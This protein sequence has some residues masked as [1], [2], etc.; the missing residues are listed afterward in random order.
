VFSGHLAPKALFRRYVWDRLSQAWQLKLVQWRRQLWT[1]VRFMF[2]W[3]GVLWLVWLIDRGLPDAISFQRLGIQPREWRGLLGI[4]LAPFIH[5]KPDPWYA[6]PWHLVLNTV[7]FFLLG[8]L[9][10]MGGRRVFFQAS[11]LIILGAGLGCWMVGQTDSDHY[12]ASGVIFG[13]FGFLL[14]RGLFEMRLRWLVVAGV[15]G[16]IYHE[17]LNGLVPQEGVSWSSHFFG[18][19]SGILASFWLFYLPRLRVQ[20]L[21]RRKK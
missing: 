13:W 6:I 2:A 4:P 7:P 10:V 17:I 16:L 19:L 21:L 1:H 20:R 5:L 3:S 12:G 11:V 18:F 15:V 8:T 9:V 14:T